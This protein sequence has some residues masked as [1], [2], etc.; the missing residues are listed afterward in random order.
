MVSMHDVDRLREAGLY[1]P[2]D[3]EA[4]ER[5]ELLQFNLDQGVTVDE[6]I[7]AERLGRLSYV[8]GDPHIRSTGSRLSLDELAARTDTEVETLVRLWRAAGLIDPRDD[9]KALTEADIE[10]IELCRTVSE[11]FGESV[12]VQLLRTIGAALGRI[13]EAE[14]TAFTT[15]VGGELVKHAKPVD[16]ARANVASIQLLPRLA[17]VLDVLH[18]HHI[19]ATNRRLMADPATRESPS[20]QLT[21]GF[22][23]LVGFTAWSAASDLEALAS[24]VEAFE[25]RARDA[26]TDR[27]GRV[28][29][30]IGDEVMFVA[31]DAATAC[32]VARTLVTEAAALDALPTIRAGLACGKVLTG[33]GDYFGPAVNLASRLVS[34]AEPGSILVTDEIRR[35]ATRLATSGA[36]RSTGAKRLKGF[37]ELIETYELAVP[38]A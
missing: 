37:P 23:D 28:V 13:A 32:D 29:K 27:G 2:A 9:D 30:M 26:V 3:A 38:V 7:E 36:F 19:H 6:L 14:V 25:A 24:L 18:R 15:V 12:T 1:D 34:I 22:A 8:G 16:L 21:V 17:A 11:V 33:Y 4:A 35:H 10:V 20:K 5:L 31:D